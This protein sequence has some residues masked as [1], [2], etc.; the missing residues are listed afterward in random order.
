VGGL[1]DLSHPTETMRIT[2]LLLTGETFLGVRWKIRQWLP[3]SG[4]EVTYGR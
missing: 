2:R 3:R 1:Y 4:A